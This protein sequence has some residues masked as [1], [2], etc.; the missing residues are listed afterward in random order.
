VESKPVSQSFRLTNE[1]QIEKRIDPALLSAKITLNDTILRSLILTRSDSTPIDRVDDSY[2]LHIVTASKTLYL[3]R[4]SCYSLEVGAA[5]QVAQGTDFNVP[6]FPYRV[7][8][9]H[10]EEGTLHYVIGVLNGVREITRP[11]VL[12]DSLEASLFGFAEGRIR[13]GVCFKREKLVNKVKERF[14]QIIPF[15]QTNKN[16]EEVYNY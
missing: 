6:D 7:E 3:V 8:G 15:N 14:S 2:C 13:E 10:D 11:E 1:E 9:I 12:S 4:L 16:K 5:L